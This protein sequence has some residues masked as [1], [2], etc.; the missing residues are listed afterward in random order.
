MNP[1]AGVHTSAIAVISEAFLVSLSSRLV[2]GGGGGY[3]INFVSDNLHSAS[4]VDVVA[5][6]SVKN[7][8]TVCLLQ[9]KTT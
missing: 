8:Q 6:T 4:M 5:Q 9:K 2:G 1:A 7:L 3:D